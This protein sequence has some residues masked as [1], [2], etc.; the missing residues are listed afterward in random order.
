MTKN[1]IDYWA[2]KETARHNVV[3]ETETNR[4]NVATESIDISKLNEEKRHNL[5]TEDLGYKQLDE[6]KRHNIV[7]E[8]IDIGKLSETTRHNFASESLTGQNVQL[9]YAQ[10]GLGYAQLQETVRNNLTNNNIGWANAS[11]NQIK[12]ESEAALNEMKTYLTDV[13][14]LYS[15]RV[16]QAQID[17]YRSQIANLDKQTDYLNQKNIQSWVNSAGTLLRGIGSIVPK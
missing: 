12:A 10:V 15:G 6:T 7:T 8:G 2:N 13:E 9:G 16:S 5:A 11:A 3:T 4:H 14:R 1:Q 17:Y